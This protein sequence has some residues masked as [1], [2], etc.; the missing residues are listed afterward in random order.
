MCINKNKHQPCCCLR[1]CP[2]RCLAIEYMRVGRL[3]LLIWP[4]IC[5]SSSLLTSPLLAKT[6]SAIGTQFLMSSNVSGISLA[7]SS[8][9]RC[10]RFASLR[11]SGIPSYIARDM[12][13]WSFNLVSAQS[14][15]NALHTKVSKSLCHLIYMNK[16][17]IWRMSCT[18]SYCL[19][20]CSSKWW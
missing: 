14:L 13:P 20:T 19:F 1:L 7:C 18:N 3:V 9:I 12:V 11:H 2:L 4:M 16:R 8:S 6:P 17:D 15:N 5:S 10:S